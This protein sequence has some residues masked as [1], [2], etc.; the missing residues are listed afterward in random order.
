MFHTQD[1][2]LLDLIQ[3]NLDN[4][5]PPEVCLKAGMQYDPLS[6]LQEL[7]QAPTPTIQPV[8]GFQAPTIQGLQGPQAAQIGGVSTPQFRGLLGC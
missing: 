6:G 7:A 1:H 8:T 5:K 4:F 2:E 3:I